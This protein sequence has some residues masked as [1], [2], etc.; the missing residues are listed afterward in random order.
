[1]TSTG[2]VETSITDPSGQAI[3]IQVTVP[4]RTLIEDAARI[5]RD[6]L[7]GGGLQERPPVLHIRGLRLRDASAVGVFSDALL[8]EYP[9]YTTG[10]HPQAA[11]SK[12]LYEPVRYAPSETLLWHHENSFAATWPRIVVF[13][14]V[15]PADNGG[16]TTLVDTRKVYERAPA[17]FRNQL[18]RF[19]I[20]YER[21]CDGV[22]GR[23]W[24][25]LYS[26]SSPDIARR[27][28]AAACEDLR[29]EGGT[30][31]IT[32]TRPA[33]LSVGQQHSWF[34]QIL[35]WHPAALPKDVRHLVDAGVIPSYRGCR[36][37]NGA[38]I[39]DQDIALLRD[40]HRDT[41]VVIPW[42]PGDVVVVDNNVLAH[43]RTPYEGPREHYVRLAG[44]ARWP[45]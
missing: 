1:M 18:H 33:F 26:T 38:A 13:L 45:Q 11:A 35:H 23:T 41:Q 36:L 29:F 10:E 14:C 24:Q 3:G 6:K 20:R 12:A 21:I 27:R 22:V 8:R 7:P 5:L 44:I 4:D 43:G 19:G 30:A 42:G 15:R 37:G 34:N 40:I 39:S 28:A 31:R 2:W 32:F 25:Q 16:R 17:V 9:C